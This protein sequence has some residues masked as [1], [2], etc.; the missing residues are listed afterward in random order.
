M[1]GRR[2]TCV[3]VPRA[4]DSLGMGYYTPDARPLNVDAIL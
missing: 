4:G 1:D 3:V 2:N